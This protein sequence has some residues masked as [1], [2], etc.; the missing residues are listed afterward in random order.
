MSVTDI[1]LVMSITDLIMDGGRLTL[2][3]L[4]TMRMSIIDMRIV[5]NRHN[6]KVNNLR[7][8]KAL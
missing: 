2:T 1:N 5:D 4:S 6:E 8:D 7:L 3:R